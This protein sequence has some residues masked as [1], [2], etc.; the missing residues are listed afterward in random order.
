[1]HLVLKLA[2]PRL[3]PCLLYTVPLHLFP[4]FLLFGNSLTP[5]LLSSL[6][7]EIQTHRPSLGLPLILGAGVIDFNLRHFLLFLWLPAD[8]GEQAGAILGEECSLFEGLMCEM[9]V[10]IGVA[11]LVK[12]VHV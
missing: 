6:L 8:V 4:F 5:N 11:L 12:P 1:M 9:V 3:L 2:V 10:V 7:L